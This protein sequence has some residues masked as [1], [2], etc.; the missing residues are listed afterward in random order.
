MQWLQDKFSTP[1]KN[2]IYLIRTQLNL[3]MVSFF[4]QLLGKAILFFYW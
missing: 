1:T 3:Y 4:N 2:Y